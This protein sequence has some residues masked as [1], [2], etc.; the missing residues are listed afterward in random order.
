M[1]IHIRLINEADLGAIVTIQDSCYAAELF[2]DAGLIR[3]RLASQPQSCW[4]AEDSKGEV[5]A[6]LFSYPSR[7]NQVAPLGSSF[8]SYADAELLYLHDMAVSHNARGMR[9]APQLL[10]LAEQYAADLGFNRLALVAVQGS[11]PYWQKQGFEMVTLTET[12]ALQA[13]ASYTGQNAVYMQKL[14]KA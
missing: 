8:G 6:Y 12:T 11:V 1:S 10:A 4:L 9:L 5:L 13:L 2:E 14:L 3:R 7:D